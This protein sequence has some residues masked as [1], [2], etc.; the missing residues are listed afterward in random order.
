[1]INLCV[2]NVGVFAE[3][4]LGYSFYMLCHDNEKGFKKKKK[5]MNCSWNLKWINMEAVQGFTFGRRSVSAFVKC[6]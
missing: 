1:M 3:L 4:G 2:K 6:P 5:A